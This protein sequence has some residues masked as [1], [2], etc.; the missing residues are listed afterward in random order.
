MIGCDVW[1][2]LIVAV[3]RPRSCFQ[4]VLGWNGEDAEKVLS[5]NARHFHLSSPIKL[6]AGPH[7]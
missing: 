6:I 5:Y 4:S 7:T 1:F 3:S 2:D